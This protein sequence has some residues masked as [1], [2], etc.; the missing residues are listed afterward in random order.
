MVFPMGMPSRKF[1]LLGIA[2]VAGMAMLADQT[3]LSKASAGLGELSGVVAE[4]KK[5][6]AIASSLESGDPNALQG[7]L[8]TLATD[9]GVTPGEASPD[10]FGLASFMPALASATDE[11]QADGGD[12][13]AELLAGPTR[14]EA[15]SRPA[16]PA[17]RV[18]MVLNASNGGIAVIDG[19][20]IRAGQTIDGM[21][22]LRVHEDG[23][24]VRKN[25]SETFLSLR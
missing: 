8:E 2:G 9:E 20:P 1:L 17:G 6:Q 5:V 16:A 3:L 12:P 22:L 23:V 18:T 7:L 10:L 24:T 25:E 4:V 21:T 14:A 13:I 11:N 15:S 19:N